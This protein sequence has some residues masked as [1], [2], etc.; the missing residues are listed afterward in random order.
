M[1]GAQ[2]DFDRGREPHRRDTQGDRR[3]RTLRALHGRHDFLARLDRLPPRRV[4]RGCHRRRL[5]K[6]PDAASRP[7]VQLRERE[8]GQGVAYGCAPALVLGLGRD[9]FQQPERLFPL[10][11]GDQPALRPARIARDARGGGP[12]KRLR[13]PCAPRG[14]HAA[15]GARLGPGGPVRGARGIF[16][17]AHRGDD[18]RRP[19]RRRAAQD[20]PRSLRHVAR[21]RLG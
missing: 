9:A 11:A 4:G 1:R 12:A 20:H 2:R 13:P 3:G 10:H 8:G 18:A 7:V 5:A 16:E 19:R 17:L 21:Y 15:R 6:R 14:E